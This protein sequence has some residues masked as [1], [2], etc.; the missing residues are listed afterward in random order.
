M[1]LFVAVFGGSFGFVQPLQAA[2]VAFVQA[3][4]FVF[5]YPELVAV[6]E[7]EVQGLDGAFLVGGEGNVK[8]DTF[9]FQ[10]LA[11][12]D[13]FFDALRG[14]IN[15]HPAGEA[16]GQVPFTLA[17]AGKDEFHSVSWWDW[18]N[19]TLKVTFR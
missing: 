19:V 13:G 9:F 18:G 1:Y 4:A 10:Q 6:F 11:A 15:I 8:L 16:V 2:V 14:E 12:G 7:Q 5:G 17:V 3:P